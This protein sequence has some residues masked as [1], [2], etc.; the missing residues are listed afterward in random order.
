MSVSFSGQLAFELHVPNEQL[1][2]IWQ[3]LKSAGEG[4]NLSQLGLYST[5]SMRLEKGY[6]HWKAEI[7]DEFNPI[8]AGLDR[9]VQFNKSDFVGKQALLKTLAKGCVKKI[10]T[11]QVAC[12]F[13]LDQGG[14]PVFHNNK[15]VGVV[16]SAG[17]GHRVN[18]N[19]AFAYVDAEL[20]QINQSFTV[21]IIGI[22]CAA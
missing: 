1:Y 7:I 14:D 6:L 22:N 18:K 2:F 17:Y 10:V 19:L 5:E 13:A 8:E 16:S 20:A 11:L 9:F 12:E 21:R 3:L 4:F 15:Q